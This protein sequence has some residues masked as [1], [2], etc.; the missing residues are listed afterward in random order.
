LEEPR[1]WIAKLLTQYCSLDLQTSNPQT[2]KPQ[3]SME[4]E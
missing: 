4:Q 1:L 2:P 3:M